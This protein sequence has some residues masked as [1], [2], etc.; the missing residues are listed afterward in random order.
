MTFKVEKISCCTQPA[1]QNL[2][3]TD[4]YH[5]E[6]RRFNDGIAQLFTT[7]IYHLYKKAASTV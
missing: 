4:I 3:S 5:L 7:H 1:A 2:G 6:T